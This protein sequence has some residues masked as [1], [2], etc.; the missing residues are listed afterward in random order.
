MSQQFI[1]VWK[2]VSFE[3]HRGDQITYP[4]GHDPSGYLIY[5]PDGYMSAQMMTKNRQQ[6][7]VNDARSGTIEEYANAGKTYA[8]Y[9]GRYEVG[10]STITHVVEVSYFPNYVGQRLVRYFTFDGDRLTLNT[11]PVQVEGEQL[12]HYIVWQKVK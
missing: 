2:M 12:I 10:E 6:F 1:S 11:S 5:T 4:G 7:A 3:T 9:C 8:G